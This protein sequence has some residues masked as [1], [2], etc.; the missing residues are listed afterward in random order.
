M[1]EEEK[2]ALFDAYLRNQLSIKDRAA[3]ETLKDKNETFKNDFENYQNLSLDIKN[4]EE[5]GLIKESLKEIHA[6]LIHPKKS[7]LVQAKFLIPIISAAAVLLFLLTVYPMNENGDTAKAE[8][9]G[10][11]D[12]YS[13][14]ENEEGAVEA[15]EA[16]EETD[17]IYYESI[18]EEN[19]N[20][21]SSS[22][23]LNEPI[24]YLESIPLGTSFQIS[25]N[26]YFITAKHLVHKKRYVQLHNKEQ[27]LA[28][29]TEVIY[30]DTL[31]DFALLKCSDSIASLLKPCPY[32]IRSTKPSLG[33]EVFTLGYPKADIVYTQGSISSSKGYHSDSLTFEL[34]MASNDGNSGAPLFTKTG[35]FTGFIIANNSKKQSV[36]Y[37]VQPAYIYDRIKQLDDKFDINMS[38]NYSQNSQKTSY[39]IG[40]FTPF[41]FE[42]K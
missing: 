10:A 16:F 31:T 38:K 22:N 26:G 41:I 23:L 39:L 37:I 21:N 17:S 8:N 27:N 9:T 30:R 7:I 29:Y 13:P 28:F 12:D 5:Y 42:L 35:S 4:G 32:K 19:F 33:D 3:F 34:S 24:D 11:E 2:I 15:T 6:D 20:G 25:E 1:S 36:T 14:T 18:D 40:K